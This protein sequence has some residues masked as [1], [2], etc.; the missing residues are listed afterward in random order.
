MEAH[1]QA[2][3][4]AA[5]AQCKFN[6]TRQNL[7][8]FKSSRGVARAGSK[9]AKQQKEHVSK[10]LACSGSPPDNVAQELLSTLLYLSTM[11]DK[12]DGIKDMLKCHNNT[13]YQE[14]RPL[15]DSLS[16]PASML[17]KESNQNER[18]KRLE[19]RRRHYKDEVG[20]SKM[21]ATKMQE[22]AKATESQF[23][24]KLCAL[25]TSLAKLEG[26]LVEKEDAIKTLVDAN[27]IEKARHEDELN[28]S[29]RICKALQGKIDDSEVKI[30][31]AQEGVEKLH[32]AA[33]KKDS[34]IEELRIKIKAKCKSL[35]RLQNE[36]GKVNELEKLVKHKDDEISLLRAKLEASDRHREELAKIIAQQQQQQPP[37]P[38]P[39]KE[40]KQESV[41]KLQLTI[42]AQNIPKKADD[43]SGSTCSTCTDGDNP[44]E[45]PA[46]TYNDESASPRDTITRRLRIAPTGYDLKRKVSNEVELA[47][48]KDD[49]SLP[50]QEDEVKVSAASACTRTGAN[51]ENM[52]SSFLDAN[53]ED[54]V[55]EN[56]I[57]DVVEEIFFA[58]EAKNF[59]CKANR[60][61]GGQATAI[62]TGACNVN[63]DENE[64][65][66]PATDL[67][68]D[69]PATV[70]QKTV[71]DAIEE[72]V[73][74]FP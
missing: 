18:I 51:I 44:Y 2:V 24:E 29:K 45:E 33:R 73:N 69:G 1:E 46:I 59:Q 62:C 17:R 43:T 53:G 74:A 70:A 36:I 47:S 52:I 54:R 55:E 15:I 39:P 5:L 65:L 9:H 57:T 40:Q 42:V 3:E 14:W 21:E 56:G 67:K 41:D 71:D 26:R 8:S 13:K 34:A 48:G 23:G 30:Q 63:D 27:S 25:S 12:V 16:S 10:S 7:Q 22:A 66:T 50:N 37:P 49:L 31:E 60:A 28:E 68:S 19:K 35:E 38:P 61:N 32:A 4:M 72:A 20:K 11:L 58:A 64:E 6:E